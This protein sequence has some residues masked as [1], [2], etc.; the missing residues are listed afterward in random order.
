MCC[1]HCGW[2]WALPCRRVHCVY[3]GVHTHMHTHTE[4]QHAFLICGAALVL[5]QGTTFNTKGCHLLLYLGLETYMVSLPG[6]SSS[7]CSDWL[8]HWR[9]RWI[10]LF[11]NSE[12]SNSFTFFADIYRVQDPFDM[13]AEKNQTATALSI[14]WVPKISA[15]MPKD[16]AACT[17]APK[18]TC[19]CVP[20]KVLILVVSPSSDNTHP[21]PSCNP[22]Y[23][24]CP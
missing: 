11:T 22:Y 13:K 3:I 20:S 23:L 21:L 10:V 2:G 24:E 18:H 19:A 7:R 6:G 5:F 12:V 8:W 14:N 16:R 17:W 4:S 1:I 9:A 15:E